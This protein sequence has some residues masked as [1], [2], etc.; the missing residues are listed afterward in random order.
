MPW[1]LVLGFDNPDFGTSLD[2]A[3]HDELNEA[4][5][6]Y[7]DRVA[8]RLLARGPMLRANHDG[9]TGSVHV[10]SAEFHAAAEQFAFSE[11]YFLAGLYETVEV[12][13]FAPWLGE[14]MWTRPG[15]PTAG[16]SWL[17]LWRCRGAVWSKGTVAVPNVPDAVLC[18]GWLVDEGR[19]LLGA[20]AL[21]D[22]PA[23]GVAAIV[24]QLAAQLPDNGFELSLIPWRRG[25]RL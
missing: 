15:D 21:V 9:H 13:G 22:A 10:L 6:S 12:I 24:A 23:P 19:T 2:Q 14:S 5:W 18:A 3:A 1:F 4:H 16:M 11:P 7:M 8:N 17:A 20:A 25:G